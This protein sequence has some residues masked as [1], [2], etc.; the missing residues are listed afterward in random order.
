M[1]HSFAPKIYTSNE[2]QIQSY[3]Y[4]Q[5]SISTLPLKTLT[6]GKWIVYHLMN[7]FWV[8]NIIQV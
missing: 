4:N 1:H 8:L 6:L 2:H 5:I 3:H 7:F